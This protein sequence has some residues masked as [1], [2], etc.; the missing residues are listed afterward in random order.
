MHG[1]KDI[2]LEKI[3]YSD[4][5]KIKEDEADKFAEK[6]T[7]TEE[8]EVEI[9]NAVQLS[10]QDIRDFSLKLNT[11]PAII[12]GR[13]QHKKKP[14]SFGRKYLEPVVFE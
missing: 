14:Y 8:Q 5:D 7:L 3:E 13:L 6:C 9:L 2:F 4:K 11:H 12:I 1:K 10:E